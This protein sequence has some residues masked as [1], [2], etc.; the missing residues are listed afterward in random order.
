MVQLDGFGAAAKEGIPGLEWFD[1]FQGIEKLAK[2]V[3]GLDFLV[4]L[5]VP[6]DVGVITSLSQGIF[7]V[8]GR[9]VDFLQG[10]VR[11]TDRVSVTLARK[12]LGAS[13]P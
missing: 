12:A 3:V 11:V 8:L 7:F 10:T 2:F 1:D 13:V 5:A 9:L 4:P 6:H